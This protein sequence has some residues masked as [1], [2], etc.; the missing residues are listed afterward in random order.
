MSSTSNVAGVEEGGL[1]LAVEE[2]QSPSQ[3]CIPCSVQT[4]AKQPSG[5]P[6]MT[7]P[8]RYTRSPYM[9]HPCGSVVGMSE[10]N[11]N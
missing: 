1:G 9:S 5:S 7:S 6:A 8:G 2:W 4:T 11:G 3:I 10:L